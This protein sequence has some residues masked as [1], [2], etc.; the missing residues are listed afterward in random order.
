VI[1]VLRRYGDRKREWSAEELVGVRST[2]S[3]PAGCGSSSRAVA[4]NCA[5]DVA[6]L[7]TKCWAHNARDR[8]SM[9][10]AM[11]AIGTG[12]RLRRMRLRAM[13]TRINCWLTQ[14]ARAA[15]RAA[16][17]LVILLRHCRR[18]HR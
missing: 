14:N 7:M 13:T 12:G 18:L 16:R 4:N 17:A 10:E 8:P 11:E 1:W 15:R 9:R 6:R 2:C 5:K 3:S